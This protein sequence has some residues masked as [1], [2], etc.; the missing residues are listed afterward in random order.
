MNKSYNRITP[1]DILE[2]TEVYTADFYNDGVLLRV[3]ER[4]FSI[5]HDARKLGWNDAD[6][7]NK[8]ESVCKN[9]NIDPQQYLQ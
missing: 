8:I 1:D 3:I 4:D 6:V 5:L 9:L 2:V 7:R